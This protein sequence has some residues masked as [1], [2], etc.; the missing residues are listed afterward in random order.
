M[1]TKPS[2]FVLE[3]CLKQCESREVKRYFSL[4]FMDNEKG[5]YP[6]LFSGSLDEC[7][8]KFNELN[9]ENLA[10]YKTPF[11]CDYIENLAALGQKAESDPVVLEKV[12]QKIQTPVKPEEVIIGDKNDYYGMKNVYFRTDLGEI[13]VSG[14]KNVV[15]KSAFVFDLLRCTV[16]AASGIGPSAD[17]TYVGIIADVVTKCLNHIYSLMDHNQVYV[18]T[19]NYIGNAQY[20]INCVQTIL[21]LGKHVN[22][23]TAIPVQVSTSYDLKGNVV[24]T[25]IE[26][27]QTS[28]N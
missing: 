3:T 5:T 12:N 27:C 19:A 23:N 22:T 17:K 28:S 7:I 14:I 16:R 2:Y 8:F 11:V 21:D 15:E 24:K 26:V 18:D 1:Q 6:P 25:V 10:L 9:V 13:S 4:R 20:W